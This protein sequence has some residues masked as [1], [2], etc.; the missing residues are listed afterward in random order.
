[1]LIFMNIREKLSGPISNKT[2]KIIVIERDTKLVVV[3]IQ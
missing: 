1:V 2:F 3:V